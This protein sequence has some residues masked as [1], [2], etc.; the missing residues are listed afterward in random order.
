MQMIFL[1]D[2]ARLLQCH[3]KGVQMRHSCTFSI[4]CR[5]GHRK[6]SLLGRAE[7]TETKVA[8]ASAAS[9]ILS[10]VSRARVADRE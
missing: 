2:C 7:M 4:Q 8:R 5:N 6:I 10:V 9:N 3:G 1:H